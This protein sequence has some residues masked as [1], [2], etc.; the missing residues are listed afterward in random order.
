MI[1]IKKA[2]LIYMMEV[3]ETVLTDAK[4]RFNLLCCAEAMVLLL[5]IV[6]HV[7]RG[8][9]PNSFDLMVA[10]VDLLTV[11][12]DPDAGAQLRD[13]KVQDVS[14]GMVQSLLYT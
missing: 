14:L 3:H 2:H 1:F 12:A 6:K 13:K 8:P 10:I 5:V 7:L 11:G 4:E 9:E